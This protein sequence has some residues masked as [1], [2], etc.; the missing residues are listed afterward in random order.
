MILFKRSP[1]GFPYLD[2]EDEDA[3]IMINTIRGK[4]EGYTK[5]EIKAAH[6]VYKARSLLGNLSEA[7]LQR[8]IRTQSV[9][10][11]DTTPRDVTNSSAIYGPHLPGVRGK[12]VR[13]SPDHVVTDWVEKVPRVIP[14]QECLTL[15]ADVF[16]VNEIPFLLTVSRKIKFCTVEYIPSRTA[17]QLD[18]SLAKVCRLYGRASYKVR[19][20][21]LDMEFQPVQDFLPE[22]VI[23]NC[24]AAREHVGE[25]KH[26]IRTMKELTR[27][28]LTT[29]PYSCL[30]YTSPSPR[31]MRRSRMPSS[32]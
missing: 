7:D 26:E 32:A 8:M 20:I 3:F 23:C 16:F 19:V 21:L 18:S 31:D 24:A 10:G 15:A 6:Q 28:T 2:L 4:L 5:Q 1:E 27:G 29:L 9:T 25:V 14:S 30:L 12:T 17:E 22:N 13:K 11:L